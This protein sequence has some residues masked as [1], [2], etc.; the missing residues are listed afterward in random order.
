MKRPVRSVKKRGDW[1]TTRSTVLCVRLPPPPFAPLL[2]GARGASRGVATD[3][4]AGA[5]ATQTASAAR[6]EAML[7]RVLERAAPRSVQLPERK[8][9]DV[10]QQ[11][12]ARLFREERARNGQN[13]TGE[14]TG[15]SQGEST[16]VR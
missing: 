7:E 6:L 14:A 3:T 2:T 15:E 11:E 5:L 4:G 16:G 12:W 10:A 1:A 13:E 8:P 9:Q